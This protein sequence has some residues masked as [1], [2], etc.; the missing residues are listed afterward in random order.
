ME[1]IPTHFTPQ[2][3]N[4]IQYRPHYPQTLLELLQ[5]ECHLTQAQVI[6]D[7]GSGTGILTELF[8]KNDNQ[9]FGIEP[10]PDMRAGG[11]YY[12][13]AYPHFISLAATAEATTLAEQS[14]DFVTVGQ[15]FHW[16]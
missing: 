11:E 3:N 5:R 16:F 9:V 6:A 12:L 13:R 10:N 1:D 4:Y 14:V 7:I 15:A 2:V 8:L